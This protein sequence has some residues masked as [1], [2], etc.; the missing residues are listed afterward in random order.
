LGDVSPFGRIY[1]VRAILFATFV[2][3]SGLGAIFLKEQLFILFGKIH[4]GN[5]FRIFF[6][7]PIWSPWWTNALLSVAKKTSALNNE[8]EQAFALWLSEQSL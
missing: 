3:G 6:H 2:S 7:S 4:V 5:F 1:P 8:Q